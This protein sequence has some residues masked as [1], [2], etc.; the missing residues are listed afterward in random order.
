MLESIVVPNLTSHPIISYNLIMYNATTDKL[1]MSDM[2]YDHL[3]THTHT[4]THTCTHSPTHTLSLSHTHTHTYTSH[5][6][7]HTH[8]QCFL[9]PKRLRLSIL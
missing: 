8:T 2:L 7:T 4:H 5:I 6:H 1:V 9:C 3:D